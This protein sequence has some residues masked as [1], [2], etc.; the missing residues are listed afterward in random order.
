MNIGERIKELRIRKGFSQEELATRANF[1]KSYIQKFEEG[2]REIK[3]SQLVQLSDAL[4]VDVID[5][6]MNTSYSSDEFSLR[7]IEF[8]ESEKIAIN[9][10]EF[11][12]KILGKF[13][14]RNYN[15]Y[16]KIE[17]YTGEEIKFKNPLMKEDAIESND[18]IEKI[19]ELLRK[20]WNF[21]TTPI[22]DLIGFLEEIGVK[23][24]EIS[25]HESF[26]GF[27]CWEKNTPI[28]VINVQNTDLPRRRFT[29]LHELAHLI[30]KFKEGESHDKIEKYCNHFAGAMLLPKEVLEK[31]V[32]SNESISLEE[33]KH[34]KSI[35]GI[36]IY[37][38][39][40]RL[41]NINIV[42][43]E[44]F[45]EWKEQYQYWNDKSVSFIGQERTSRFDYLLAKG[46]RE[47]LFSKSV[48]SELSGIPIS[49]LKDEWEA[50]KFVF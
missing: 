32:K 28:I 23:I 38:I 34:I 39:L 6:I 18:Q 25:E 30:L 47:N 7:N 4:Q 42:G 49:K 35:Y 31:Y 17:K 22:Y 9:P 2:K 14:H 45:N 8:R 29:T 46:L 43:W 26:S 48:A 20:K 41:V 10:K 1:S 33:L 37:A 13:L 40:V 11:E 19:A 36:S 16:K 44:K 3:S 24:F 15:A 50:K 5:L 21:G 27:S 12:E